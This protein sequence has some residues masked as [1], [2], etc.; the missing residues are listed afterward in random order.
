MRDLTICKHC[1]KFIENRI[2][3]PV[4]PFLYNNYDIDDLDCKKDKMRA[5][6][7]NRR[8]SCS[9]D[10]KFLE[11]G[12]DYVNLE[13]FKLNIPYECNYELEQEMFELNNDCGEPERQKG[14][15]PTWLFAEKR[16]CQHCGEVI[17]NTPYCP[18]CGYRRYLYFPSRANLYGI[19]ESMASMNKGAQRVFY[20]LG[21]LM[22]IFNILFILGKSMLE[23]GVLIC[24]AFN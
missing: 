19:Y 8:H 1:P 18:R 13:Y 20:M 22:L 23:L 2:S 7:Y 21:W 10:Y 14:W 4:R 6:L 3:H 11:N 5:T 9:R 17:K 12:Y 15:K 16:V 24:G